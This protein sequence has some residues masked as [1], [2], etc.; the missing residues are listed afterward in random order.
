MPDV[1]K[2]DMQLVRDVD[3]SFVKERLVT[4]ISTAA[5]ELGIR[6]VAEGIERPEEL[7]KLIVAGCDLF[8]GYLIARPSTAPPEGL[9]PITIR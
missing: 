7:R 1:I 6:V 9:G 2:L 8:Q 4:S 3:T 5:R